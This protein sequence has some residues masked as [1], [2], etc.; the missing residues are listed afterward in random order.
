MN[1]IFFDTNVIQHTINYSN[2]NE[3]LQI[4]MLNIDFYNENNIYLL[5]QII[6]ELD[7]MNLGY[8]EWIFRI[9]KIDKLDDIEE[10][11][12]KL[13]EN[14][15]ELIYI[16]PEKKEN[17]KLLIGDMIYFLENFYC[18]ENNPNI[19]I[20][21]Y[22]YELIFWIEYNENNTSKSIWK[23]LGNIIEN[24]FIWDREYYN[25]TYKDR[26]RTIGNFLHDYKNYLTKGEK[27]KTKVWKDALVF[28]DITFWIERL[29]I[30][31]EK[32]NI[33]F[34]SSDYKFIKEL[35][36]FKNDIT[37]WKINSNEYFSDLSPY[38]ISKLNI[39]FS[40]IKIIKLNIEELLF[41]DEKW[42][43]SKLIK[44]FN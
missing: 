21:K 35:I 44:D 17:N 31:L 38:F 2:K 36:I 9:I 37:S 24:T 14:I 19:L 15:W 39:I 1:N 43:K 12:L 10:F 34:I 40:K 27:Q 30:D 6:C 8:S 25:F 22:V 7:E 41:E 26:F 33:I 4:H 16:I 11:H 18:D 3:L 29:K 20:F 42:K 28:S 32:E 5:P 23:A 13:I